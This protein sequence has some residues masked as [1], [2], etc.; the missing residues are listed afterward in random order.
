MSIAMS[1]L[2]VMAQCFALLLDFAVVLILVRVVCSWRPAPWL[3]EFNV[4]G[5]PLVDRATRSAGICWERAFPSKPLFGHRLLLVTLLCAL[6]LRW[7][8]QAVLVVAHG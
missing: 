2:I 5:K 3:A 7:A 8:I 4:A 1:I 6:L